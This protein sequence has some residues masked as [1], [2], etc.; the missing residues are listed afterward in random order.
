MEQRKEID[1][2]NLKFK[3]SNLKFRILHGCEANIL[4]DGSIDIN[5]ETL[6]KLDYVIAGVHSQFKMSKKEMT[7]R[8]IKA[9]RNPNID[10]ISHP[11]GRILKKR[12]E[13]KI[14]FDEILKVAKET[15][16]ILEIN[17]SPYRLDL[18]GANIRKTKEAGVKMIIN[19]D[20]H[21]KEQMDFMEYG[22]SQARRGWA[23]KGDIV[24]AQYFKNLVKFF[25]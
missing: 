1:K 22:V 18:N 11:T 19:T 15:G 14:D 6:S 2:L 16:T 12:E 4:A 8:I 13:Y 9:M 21:Q 3:I 20:S 23:E 5:N 17:A 7:K 10:I 25:K 24:N